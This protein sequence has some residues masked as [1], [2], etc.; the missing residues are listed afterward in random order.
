MKKPQHVTQAA[1]G[2]TRVSGVRTSPQ[3]FD[4]SFDDRQTNSTIRRQDHSDC[5]RVL[6]DSSAK[7]TP[8]NYRASPASHV[9]RVN[10]RGLAPSSSVA[11]RRLISLSVQIDF[12]VSPLIATLKP[13][14][15]E[16]LY[17]NTVIGTLAVDGWVV[18]FGTARSGLG[19]A[20][21]RPGSSSLYK[22]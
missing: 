20:S 18:T 12:L 22:M 5:E 8:Y 7:P 19:G 14:N 1:S 6:R 17:S 15:N 13:Q 3:P 10:S 16:S 21:A 11:E 2:W 9:D 4:P